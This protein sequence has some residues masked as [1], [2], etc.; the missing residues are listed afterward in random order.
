MGFISLFLWSV[1]LCLPNYAKHYE[2]NQS[3]EKASESSFPSIW[4]LEVAGNFPQPKPREKQN[5]VLY[6]P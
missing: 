1:T 2:K 6:K 4:L 5:K 3:Q